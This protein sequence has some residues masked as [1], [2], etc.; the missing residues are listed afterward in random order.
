MYYTKLN[1]RNY[2]HCKQRRAAVFSKNQPYNTGSENDARGDISDQKRAE[3][4]QRETRRAY[5]LL[6][7]HDYWGFFNLS[8]DIVVL[9]NLCR[10]KQIV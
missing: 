8:V 4:Q 6:L 7:F 5:L 1:D 3:Q 2:R 9:H 10:V